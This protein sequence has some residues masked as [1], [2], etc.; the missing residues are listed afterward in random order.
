MFPLD[1]SLIFGGS[2]GQKHRPIWTAPGTIPS[3]K[4]KY[5]HYGSYCMYVNYWSLMCLQGERGHNTAL[6][7]HRKKFSRSRHGSSRPRHGHIR[8]RHGSARSMHDIL[9]NLS[10]FKNSSTTTPSALS[11]TLTE[12]VVLRALGLPPPISAMEAIPTLF[13][14]ANKSNP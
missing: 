2:T 5:T 3:N 12:Y 7:G 9:L 6:H 1:L 4:C 8:T 10:D 14:A 13:N 11:P